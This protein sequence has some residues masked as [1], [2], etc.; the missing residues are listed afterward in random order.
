MNK[1]FVTPE[2]AEVEDINDAIAMPDPPFLYDDFGRNFS[3][4]AWKPVVS[5]DEDFVTIELTV[6]P[7]IDK[8][9]EKM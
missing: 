4:I 6:R 5:L 9:K 1:S 8:T 7:A 2:Q 3:I